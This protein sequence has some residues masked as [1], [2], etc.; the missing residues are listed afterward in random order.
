MQEFLVVAAIALVLIF[1]PR[2]MNRKPAA[3]PEQNSILIIKPLSGWMRLAILVTIFWIA[4]SAAYLTP[5]NSDIILFLYVGL[6]PVVAGW[7][8]FWVWCGYKKYR[9]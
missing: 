7:G 1:V 8:V 9:H 5:W 4:G 2:L 3:A 6:G